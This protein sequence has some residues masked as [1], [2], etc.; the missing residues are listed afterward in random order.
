MIS[1][2][3]PTYNYNIYPLVSEIKQQCDEAGIVYEIISLDDASQSFHSENQNINQLSNCSYEILPKN[4]G[5][6]GI[7]NLLAK[8]AKYEWLLFLDADVLPKNASFIKN[9]LSFINK[10]EEAINGG[11]EY[12]AQAPEKNKMFRWVY[13]N[14]REA[15]PKL[16]RDKNPYPSF[17]SLNFIIKKSVFENIRFNEKVPN[18]RNEDTLFSFDLMQHKVRVLHIDNPVYHLGLDDFKIA[19]KK[20]N[21]SVIA[22]KF[23]LDNQLISP[24]YTKLAKTYVKIKKLHLGFVFILM[25]HI[26]KPL[27]IKNLSSQKPSMLMFDLYRLGYLC[28]L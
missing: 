6:S 28:T 12:S 4:L 25:H 20:E 11:I 9:Y 14:K 24:D 10:N 26:A 21:E 2:L 5:R 3:I 8:K 15:Q 19:I 7:R 1:V 13:G 18:L 17:L 16:S 27:F 23:L 22:L